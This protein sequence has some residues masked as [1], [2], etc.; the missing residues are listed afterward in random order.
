MKKKLSVFDS[1]GTVLAF[2]QSERGFRDPKQG[3][4][5]P[6]F[7]SQ[8]GSTLLDQPTQACGETIVGLWGL[9]QLPR[10]D[11]AWST[12]PRMNGP[13]KGCLTL[14]RTMSAKEFMNSLLPIFGVAFLKQVDEAEMAAH[15]KLMNEQL[16]ARAP[17]GWKYYNN[18]ARF[19]V[20]NE[21]NGHPVEELI[22]TAVGCVDQFMPM[23]NSHSYKCN[24]WVARM[25]VPA[26]RDQELVGLAKIPPGTW[27]LEWNSVWM[28]AWNKAMAAWLRGIYE[29]Q[30]AA[31]LAAGERAQALRME[32]HEQFM[33]SFQRKQDARNVQ[34]GAGEYRKRWNTEN[35]LDHV[36][37]CTRMNNEVSV[38]GNCPARQTAPY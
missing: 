22:Q 24:V 32:Q 21:V 18:T 34:V 27:S 36:L 2:P 14:R 16:S 35:F 28:D 5:L 33:Q 30:T 10:F 25:G 37:D 38:G 4:D 12:D 17:R 11:W 31:M 13:Y 23:L 7:Y 15:D 9:Y 26:G 20:R 19:V 1:R 3:R 8:G 6:L 29:R